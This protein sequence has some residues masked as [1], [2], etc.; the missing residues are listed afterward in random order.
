MVQPESTLAPGP[1]IQLKTRP[2]FDLT[3]AEFF[4]LCQANRDLRFERDAEGDVLI[5]SPTGGDTGRRGA[6]ITAHLV[7]WAIAEGS[8]TAF[9]SSTGF[10]LPDGSVRSPDASWVI[11]T[12]FAALSETE[13]QGFAP[14]CPDFVLE[15]RSPSDG[16]ASLEA[17]MAGYIENGARLAWLIDP[18]SRRV[19]VCR[20]DSAPEWLKAPES[21]S[22][23]PELPG[24]V[25]PLHAIWSP[26]V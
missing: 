25:L 5:M 9:D 4:A 14:L 20:P 13:R 2:A 3:D 26:V 19:Q 18:E 21:L 23:D 8:G 15:L 17:K 12:R 16:L 10:R 7:M 11:N 1:T 24:F 22:G 6:W